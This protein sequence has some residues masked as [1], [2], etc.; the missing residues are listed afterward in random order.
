MPRLWCQPAD[1][2]FSLSNCF[3]TYF[4]W[5]CIPYKHTAFHSLILPILRLPSVS[6]RQTSKS[7][8]CRNKACACKAK[9]SYHIQP[10]LQS[11]HWLPVTHC[12]L[13]KVLIICFN[14]PSWA[15]TLNIFLIWYN[16]TLPPEND[17]SAS[18]IRTFVTPRV[19]TASIWQKIILIYASPS[20]WNSLPWSLT[21]H[22]I[23]FHHSKLLLKPKFLKSVSNLVV[24]F[25]ATC[26]SDLS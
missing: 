18:D 14:I 1:R 8:E 24:F 6:A 11:L 12:I 10:I 20:V 16:S 17:I 15:N 4:V 2:R 22:W 23:F 3:S 13:S 9:K 26:I 21:H 25:T 7:L 19:N 5:V